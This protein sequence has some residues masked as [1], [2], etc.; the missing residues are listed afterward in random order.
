MG[1]PGGQEGAWLRVFAKGSSTM[2]FKIDSKWKANGAQRKHRTRSAWRPIRHMREDEQSA[3]CA[4]GALLRET[5]GSKG[6]G[7]GEEVPSDTGT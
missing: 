1:N 6:V 7:G 5:K 3:I 4:Q 2:M